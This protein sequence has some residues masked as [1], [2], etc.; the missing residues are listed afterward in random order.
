MAELASKVTISFDQDA[1]RR[2]DNTTKAI[3]ELIVEMKKQY[4]TTTFVQTIEGVP[5]N[6]QIPNVFKDWDAGRG[7]ITVIGDD[8]FLDGQGVTIRYQSENYHKA[9]QAIVRGDSWRGETTCVLPFGHE[10]VNHVDWDGVVKMR[11]I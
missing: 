7:N 6:T 3:K 4:P 5:A 11:D 8:I 1:K 9:C 2:L 10:G